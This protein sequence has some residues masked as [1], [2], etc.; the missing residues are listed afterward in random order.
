MQNATD[1]PIR[2][3]AQ[4]AAL[5]EERGLRVTFT[6]IC[7]LTLYR[8][9]LGYL[10]LTELSTDEAQY[11]AWG[12][13]SSFG[14]Y[15]KPPL[16][17]WIIRA[18]TELFGHSVWAVRLPAAIIHAAT[19]LA[20]LSLARRIVDQR[21]AAMAALA[22]LTAP[23]VALG[24]ALMTTD[25]P[26]LLASALALIAQHELGRARLDRRPGFWLAV[27]LGAAVGIGLLAKYAMAYAIVGMIGAAVVSSNWRIRGRDLLTAVTVTIIVLLPHLGWLASHGF[28][29]FHHLARSSGI[30][31]GHPSYGVAAKFILD[32]LMVIG[33]V[34]FPACLLAMSRATRG[35]DTIALTMLAAASLLIVLCQALAGK[36]LANWAVLYI[37]PGSILAAGLLADRPRLWLVSLTFGLAISLALPLAKV[38]ATGLR[39]LDGR[40]AM[41]R[42]LG[43]EPL[44][45]WV[46]NGADRVGARILVA[47]DR[48]ILADLTWFGTPRG[49]E[50]RAVPP[51]FAPANHW[52]LSHPF[53]AQELRRGEKALLV[54]RE[55]RLHGCRDAAILDRM[56]LDAGFGQGSTVVLIPLAGWGCLAAEEGGS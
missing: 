38:A 46:L 32:Q 36:A 4:G 55:E 25:T 21:I 20:I 9:A 39:L 17:G 29:T 28:V 12:Q 35:S 13:E 14:A 51:K 49:Y 10:D 47:A 6:L 42:Y 24:S 53:E 8:M 41:A 23:A 30:E 2:A 43:H 45:D 54:L 5:A 40:L 11:W 7:A 44:A 37:V 16:I 1:V 34:L 48:D 33:P 19:A 56:H 50:V 3:D 22:Y 31:G 27:G 18:S 15:S 52:Q 26:L